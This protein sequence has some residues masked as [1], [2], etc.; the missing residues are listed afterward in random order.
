M[1]KKEEKAQAAKENKGKR[2]E[3]KVSNI[4]LFFNYLTLTEI[5]LIFE[6]C[7]EKR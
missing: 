2:A 5:Y 6:T 4:V 3:K 1:L 7:L